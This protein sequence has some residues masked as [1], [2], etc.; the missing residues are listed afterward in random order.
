MRTIV[1]VLV[2]A[3][4]GCRAAE[5]EPPRPAAA[6]V[7]RAAAAAADRATLQL[8]VPGLTCE[9]CA[10]QIRERIEAA[11][12]V[13]R[14]ETSVPDHRV[15]VGYDPAQTDPVRLAAEFQRIGYPATSELR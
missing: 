10:W 15:T 5:A 2:L 14:V 11:A 7:R 8:R 9:G 1:L 6:P 12:G 3:V 4:A 13:A